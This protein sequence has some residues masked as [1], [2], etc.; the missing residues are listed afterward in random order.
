MPPIGLA[1]MKYPL[2]NRFPA[3]FPAQLPLRSPASL[4]GAPAWLSEGLTP[5][6]LGLTLALGF[7][8]GCIPLVGVT[9]A[10]CTVVALGLRLNLAAMLAASWVAMPLQLVLLFPYLRLGQWIFPGSRSVDTASLAAQL[11]LAPVHALVA[12]SDIFLHALVAWL[13]TAGPGAGLLMVAL[14]VVFGRRGRVE[15]EERV[16]R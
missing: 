6:Q 9:T 5:R 16:S 13:I 3:W 10:I 2:P 14:T 4:A 15:S 1:K 7:A 12:L 11:Q 8:I